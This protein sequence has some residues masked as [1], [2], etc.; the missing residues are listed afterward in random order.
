MFYQIG[1][2]PGH[3]H[4]GLITYVHKTYRSE[5]ITINLAATG[6]KYLSTEILHNS[7]N[8][9]KYVLSNV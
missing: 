2:C 8:T 5:K 9:K 3:G 6:W 4:S 7:P 1:N